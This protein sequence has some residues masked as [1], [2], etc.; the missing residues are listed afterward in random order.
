[1][2]QANGA[3]HAKAY[4]NEALSKADYY[5]DDQE[6]AGRMMGK[7]ADRLGL[8]GPVEKEVFHKLCDNINPATGGPLTPRHDKNRITGYDI[9]FS[10]PKSVSILHA[11][12]NDE[13][14]LKAFQDAVR[15]T[16]Q[17]IER[18]SKTRVRRNGLDEDRQTGELIWSEFVHQTS[19]PKDGSLPDPQLH[20]HCFV[21][22][23]TFDPVEDRIKAARFTDIKRDM[24][25]YQEL[26]FKRL[27]DRLM[28][29]GYQIQRTAKSFEVVGVP[30][31]VI[32]LFSKRTEE[33]ER[34]AEEKGITNA[35]ELSELGARTRAKKQKGHTMAELK[36]DWRRQVSELS[37]DGHE[38]GKQIVRFSQ[39][40]SK[41]DLT[42]QL[43]VDHALDH[44]FE[45]SSVVQDR[46]LLAQSYRH[47]IGHR[48]VTIDDI[49]KAFA[50]DNRLI[51]VTDNGKTLSTT[52]Q[53][54]AEEQ[55]MVNLARQGLGKLKP[56][57]TKAPE[58][59]LE[60]Q[61]ADAVSHILTTTHRVSIIRGAAGSG[62]TT[63]MKEAIAQ[64]EKAGMQVSVVA[65]T[66]QASR[67]VLREEG[68]GQ[69]E[70][71]AQLLT[72]KHR[73]EALK[74]QII[75]V[76]EAGLL[77][78]QDMTAL[79]DLAN[80]QNARLIL[81]GDTRQHSAV[82]RGDA[83]RILNTVAGIQ[84]AEVNKIYRQRN[85]DYRQAVEDLAK[86]DIASGIS[87]LEGIGFIE[88]VDPEKPHAGL[89]N[90]Y[91][92]AMR[93]GKTALVVSPTHQQSDAITRSIREK[94][95]SDRLLS[96]KEIQATRLMNLNLTEA[97]RGDWRNIKVGNVV[98]FNQNL[99]GIKRGSVWQVEASSKD[100]IIIQNAENQSVF[101]PMDKSNH[102][103]VFQKNEIALAK[104]DKIRITRNGFDLDKNRLNNGQMLEVA[105][106]SKNG[107]LVLRNDISKTEY[108]LNQDFGHIAHSY[109]M[110]SHAS[111]GKT[112][113]E[114][115]IWQ[116]AA[117]FPATDAKQFYVSV[118]RGRDRARIYTD[119]KEE[120]MTYAQRLGDRQSALELVNQ[121]KQ[122]SDVVQQKIR[123]DMQRAPINKDK[124][125]EKAQPTRK[126]E[127]DY[128]P[129]I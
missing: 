101:L 11:F 19:R 106:A 31:K 10:C 41:D 51:H 57:Y 73:Q 88:T 81:G 30:Q 28:D 34:V 48:S 114:I 105:K 104:G 93:K 78:T 25:Y 6:L 62:K 33:I 37:Q 22:N 96:Q 26:Y 116:P 43:C 29:E 42:P 80:Q 99:P 12:S 16:M 102:F 3:G 32:D 71:V 112:V 44:G 127:R 55:R 20:A 59:T 89:V 117:T 38:D 75:W 27:S 110:T 49:T 72:D 21:Q 121:K 7:L 4:F 9:S 108:R 92:D 111:Q 84:T 119:D 60:G 77:G 67:G 47:A 122:S 87:K 98:Q 65:P 68:F 18:D 52:K 128:E 120:L 103:D 91:T 58:L 118:S 46:R 82:V 85:Q 123:M 100:G 76:D 66:S 14:I 107:P 69:A 36:A 40:K 126:I 5:L 86:G 95:K 61:Q 23:A 115:L 15:R 8:P 13:H 74:N 54:L 39:D 24:P 113:D 129:R 70:T 64:M 17:D 94:L 2:I 83:L 63:L 124:P 109:C 53:V 1:M 56:L 125:K 90:A 97:E 79:L 50:D 45:R 35:K